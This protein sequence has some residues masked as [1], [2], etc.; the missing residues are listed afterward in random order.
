MECHYIFCKFFFINCK[1]CRNSKQYY[2]YWQFA[3]LCHTVVLFDDNNDDYN[4]F[5]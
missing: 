1:K 2:F 3:M 4:V 5:D